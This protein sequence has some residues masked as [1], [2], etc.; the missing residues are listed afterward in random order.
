[1][2]SL[3]NRPASIK[4]VVFVQTAPQQVVHDTACIYDQETSQA[5]SDTHN[6]HPIVRT[7]AV[8]YV[9]LY[10]SLLMYNDV[11]HA[12]GTAQQV[13]GPFDK[14]GSVGHKFTTEGGIGE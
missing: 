2:C 9:L 7:W 11:L 10:D 4:L 3:Y 12:G 6:K 8:L 1:M 14:E 5:I 13:G